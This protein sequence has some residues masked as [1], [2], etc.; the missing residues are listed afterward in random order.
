VV[1]GIEKLVRVGNPAQVPGR[2]Q[3]TTAP[4]VSRR[5]RVRG[6][7]ALSAAATRASALLGHNVVLDDARLEPACGEQLGE[8]D[9][10]FEWIR[11]GRLENYCLS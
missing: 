2:S 3:A 9:D 6:S 4:R 7:V 11:Q 10:R 8:R 1:C 5:A